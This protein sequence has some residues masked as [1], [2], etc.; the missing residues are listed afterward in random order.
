MPEA[1]LLHIAL[2]ASRGE[3]AYG[4]HIQNVN[5][6]ISHSYSWDGTLR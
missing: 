5:D 2:N 3:R 1:G 4:Y 6:Y